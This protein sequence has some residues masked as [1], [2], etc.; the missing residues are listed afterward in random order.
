MDNTDEPLEDGAPKPVDKTALFS[1]YSAATSD[2]NSN[3]EDPR[4]QEALRPAI[5]ALLE[6]QRVAEIIHAEQTIERCRGVIDRNE[7]LLEV[8][9][10]T[11]DTKTR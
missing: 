8:L 6:V 1:A 3:S 5:A 11:A 4:M 9:N 7:K 10:G 2:L